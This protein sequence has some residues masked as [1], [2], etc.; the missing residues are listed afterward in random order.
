MGKWIKIRGI[1]GE[2]GYLNTET[3]EFRTTLPDSLEE[4]QQSQSKVNNAVLKDYSRRQAR[5]ESEI[6]RRKNHSDERIKKKVWRPSLSVDKSGNLKVSESQVLAPS[7]D[8]V[9]GVDPVAKFVVENIGFAKA[10]PAIRYGLLRG[11]SAL[12]NREAATTLVGDT[13]AEQVARTQLKPFVPYQWPLTGRSWSYPTKL[14]T[15]IRFKY[16]DVE[17]NNPNLYYRQGKE[18]VSKNFIWTKSQFTPKE[19]YLQEHPEEITFKMRAGIEPGVPL[20]YPNA[21]YSKGNLWY[22]INSDYPDLLVTSETLPFSTQKASTIQGSASLSKLYEIGTRRLAHSKIGKLNNTN[23]STYT[24]DPNYGYRKLNIF[25]PRTITWDQ[26]NSDVTS[27]FLKF[28][29]NNRIKAERVSDIDRKQLREIL[30]QG[31]VDV[32][33]ITE[34]DLATA[35]Y[36]RLKEIKLT[37]PKNYNLHNQNALIPWQEEIWAINDGKNVGRIELAKGKNKYG[38]SMIENYTRNQEEPVQGISE[39]L[40]NAAIMAAKS[41]GLSGIESGETLLSPEITVNHVLPKYTNKSL[42]GNWG[43]YQWS[44]HNPNLQTT[45]NNPVYL[46]T[47]PTYNTPTKSLLF[48]PTIIDTSGKMHINWLD[49]NIFKFLIPISYGINQLGNRE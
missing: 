49:P 2:Y 7:E 4:K 29:Q 35:I 31:G 43:Q 32:S 44:R 13:L 36:N 42:V 10:I 14:D 16:G 27:N 15:N 33:K 3:G 24:L 18:G 1:N 21:L 5:Y 26:A 48:D 30:K 25:E 11:A 28:V 46:L 41:K 39:R 9:G 22:G 47:T 19:E 20:N 34:D 45:E 37:A 38:I 17:I 8:S 40:Y 12:G 6:K 23:S